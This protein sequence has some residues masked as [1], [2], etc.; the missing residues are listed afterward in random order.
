[1]IVVIKPNTPR[2]QIDEVIRE[3]QHLGYDPR[4]IFGTEQTVIA[5]IGD[6]RT[7]YTLES[8]GAFVRVMSAVRINQVCE[9]YIRRRAIRHLEKGRVTVFAAG[10]GNPFFTTDTAAALRAL[11]Q[12]PVNRPGY[13]G[14]AASISVLR[15][16][17]LVG[18]ADPRRGGAAVGV[19]VVV[20][21]VVR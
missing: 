20:R 6:E 7:H 11:G 10:T 19:D 12:I 5:A 14:D 16:G 1:M 15:G 9:D 2:E 21:E 17:A 13:L 4:P 8:L 18:V 3:V